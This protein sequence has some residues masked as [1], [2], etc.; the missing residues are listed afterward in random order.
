MDR[1][2]AKSAR[3]WNVHLKPARDQPIVGKINFGAEINA[4]PVKVCGIFS[5][6]VK[7]KTLDRMYLWEKRE[8]QTQA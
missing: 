3:Q 7:Q 1:T 2:T 8:I 4:H 5:V 6:V